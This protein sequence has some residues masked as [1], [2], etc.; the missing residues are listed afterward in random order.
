MDNNKILELP[1]PTKKELVEKQKECFNAILK[2]I[3]N[4]HYSE[5]EKLQLISYYSKQALD[6][7][8][9]FKSFKIE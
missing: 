8:I 9:V 5:I 2:V 4:E 3:D 1:K 6:D 7:S